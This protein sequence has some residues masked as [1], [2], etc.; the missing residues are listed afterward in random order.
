LKLQ[1]GTYLFKENESKKNANN[2]DHECNETWQEIG[3]VLE[4]LVPKYLGIF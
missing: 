4:E 3:I 1:S 2:S